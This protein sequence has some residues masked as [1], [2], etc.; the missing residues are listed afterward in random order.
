MLLSGILFTCHL[1]RFILFKQLR[2]VVYNFNFNSKLFKSASEAVLGGIRLDFWGPIH[3]LFVCL[4]VSWHCY[5]IHIF[6]LSSVL[7]RRINPLKFSSEEKK[8]KKRRRKYLAFPSRGYASRIYGAP[9]QAFHQ[10]CT[11]LW[12]YGPFR[13]IDFG[14]NSHFNITVCY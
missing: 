5:L 8:K 13:M 14:G 1:S 12:P 3:A 10:G 2:L 9:F 7:K 6:T 4:F 11:L